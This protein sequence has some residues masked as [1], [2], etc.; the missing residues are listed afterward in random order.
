[1]NSKHYN[2]NQLRIDLWNELKEKSNQITR[3]Q[4]TDIFESRLNEL[5]EVLQNLLSIEQYFSFPGAPLVSR[6]IKAVQKSEL[7]AVSNQVSEIVSLLVS[8]HYRLHPEMIHE[9][10]NGTIS[11][12]NNKEKLSSNTK[13]IISKFYMLKICLRKKKSL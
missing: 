6:I 12:E 2:I 9:K 4:N 10:F 7:K 8:D 5:N 11:N 13:K 1:M 3:V